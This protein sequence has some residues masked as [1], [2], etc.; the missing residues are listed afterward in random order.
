MKRTLAVLAL[1][2][3]LALG[4]CSSTVTTG[5][6]TSDAQALLAAAEATGAISTKN[7]A[8]VTEIITGFET[9]SSATE[10][11]IADGSNAT[12]TA[13][14]SLDAAIGQVAADSTNASVQADAALAETALAGLASNTAG[15][16][17]TSVEQAVA[18][19]LIDYLAAKSTASATPG[20]VSLVAKLIIEAREKIAALN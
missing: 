18:T 8:L 17:Q 12:K 3:T 5:S 1:A 16:T 9:V 14:T 19:F 10:S 13:L 7:A 11:S 15:I 20:T 2:G 4:A 6:I